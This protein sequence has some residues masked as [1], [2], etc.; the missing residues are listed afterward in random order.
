VSS[1]SGN[2]IVRGTNLA[3][4]TPQDARLTEAEQ[5][6]V[7]RLLSDPTYFPVEFRT[8]IKN[9]LEGSGIVLPQSA[10]QGGGGVAQRTNLPP[11]AIIPVAANAALPADV[12]ICDGRALVRADYINLF[13][14]I[15]T[16]WGAG[17]GTTTFN[18]PDLRDRALYGAGGK[19]G[20][21][22]TDGVAFGSRGGPDHS[23]TWGGTT[24]SQGAH[25]H[26]Y[27]GSVSGNTSSVGDHQ[28]GPG[29]LSAYA[30]GGYSQAALGSGGTSRYIIGDFTGNTASAGG[31][32]H[33]FSG[34]Y[35]GSTSSGGAHQHSVS[36]TTSGGF[37]LNHGSYAGILYGI[38]TG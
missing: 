23:H 28:H 31:H 22:G 21:A 16:T 18:I 29:V 26:S 27:S 12:L 1:V 35:S 11:G 13:N 34:S 9:Y 5:K 33:S 37:G 6:M 32:S 19:I 17:D 3:V 2:G 15:G 24:D 7:A 25:T 4:E 30:M 14:A 20:L 10:I 36:G 8:W 38:T